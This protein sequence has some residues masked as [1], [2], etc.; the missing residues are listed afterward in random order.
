[1]FAFMYTASLPLENNPIVDDHLIGLVV[2]A[3]LALGAAGMTWGFGRT[4]SRSELVQQHPV[5]R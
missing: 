5:L 2:M 1:M 4:W 3:V